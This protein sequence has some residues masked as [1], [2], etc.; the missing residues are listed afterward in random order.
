MRVSH[1]TALAFIGWYLMMPPM[2][3]ELRPECSPGAPIGSS[4]LFLSFLTA[5][6]P[7]EFMIRRCD[8][9]RHTVN[10]NAPITAWPDNDNMTAWHRI[11][12]FGTLALCDSQYQTNQSASVDM[13]FFRDTALSELTDEDERPPSQVDLERRMKEIRKGLAD[14]VA[15]ERCIASDPNNAS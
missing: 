13:N 5:T 11:G 1:A 6:S 7:R 4:A 3:A 10:I 2:A 8:Y 12:K 14:Q 9:L 15:G